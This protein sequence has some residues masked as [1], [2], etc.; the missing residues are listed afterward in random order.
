METKELQFKL[1]SI[2]LWSG[3][4]QKVTTLGAWTH[5][6][7]F[8]L[9]HVTSHLCICHT[10]WKSFFRE[11]RE[12]EKLWCLTSWA[13]EPTWWLVAPLPLA[14]GSRKKYLHLLENARYLLPAL[15]GLK[16]K[17]AWEWEVL[18]I[19]C[20]YCSL[21]CTELSALPSTAII[22]QLFI[23][24]QKFHFSLRSPLWKIIVVSLLPTA[25]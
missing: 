5:C 2:W 13:S 7:L 17:N 14:V 20:S 25:S 10:K 19:R 6:L 21:R 22:H 24:K 11:G 12:T 18:H 8:F 3:S 23:L 16:H 15:G 1:W 9:T 4:L